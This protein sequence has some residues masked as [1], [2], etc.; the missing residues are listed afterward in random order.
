[1]GPSH[2]IRATANHRL[3][4]AGRLAGVLTCKEN[5]IRGGISSNLGG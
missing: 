5:C 4:G 2:P 3:V 1:M